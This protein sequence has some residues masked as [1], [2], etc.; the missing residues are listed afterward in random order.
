MRYDLRSTTL[1]RVR[2]DL[3]GRYIRCEAMRLRKPLR[4]RCGVRCVGGGHG[5]ITNTAEALGMPKRGL[6]NARGR[7]GGLRVKE[8]TGVLDALGIPPSVFFDEAVGGVSTT[9][10][11]RFMA[12]GADLAARNLV[13]LPELTG[14]TQPDRLTEDDLA[15]LD[16]ARFEDPR[17][18]AEQAAGIGRL[19]ARDGRRG[20]AA[21]AVARQGSARRVAEEW[22]QAWVCVWWALRHAPDDSQKS[23]TWLRASFIV[24]DFG[25]FATAGDLAQHAMIGF[26]EE[27]DLLGTGR[28]LS[29]RGIFLRRS[30]R[31]DRAIP[32][33]RAAQGILPGSATTNLVAVFQNLA[34]AHLSLGD[35]TTSMAFAAKAEA[36]TGAPQS[37]SMHLRWLRARIAEV[38]QEYAIAIDL[39]HTV[40]PAFSKSPGNA[41]LASAELC[42]V[43]LKA[44]NASKAVSTAVKMSRLAVPRSQNQIVTAAI[45]DLYRSATTGALSLQV[46]KET[47]EDIRLA[48]RRRAA[49]E[50]RPADSWL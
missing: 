6:E 35:S 40:V 25:Y 29:N 34:L 30:G 20:D 9:A 21:A 3:S 31:I 23:N 18:A 17:A 45:L 33:L 42:R 24:S 4:L 26:I 5:T 48:L 39:Y 38:R 10:T 41:A 47:I 43:Y 14:D 27:G 22:E 36:V 16:A 44:G 37:F 12:R 2:S 50:A 1:P 19:A 46:V 49:G 28:A 8:V 32:V 7:P 11:E 15:R 13:D